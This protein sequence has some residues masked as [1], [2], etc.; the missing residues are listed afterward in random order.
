M[1]AEL[2]IR[3]KGHDRIDI[4]SGA[5]FC[6]TAMGLTT[7]SFFFQVHSK[8]YIERDS[9]VHYY[10]F[11]LHQDVVNAKTLHL[12]AKGLFLVPLTIWNLNSG[13][14][15]HMFA[16]AHNNSMVTLHAM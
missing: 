3:L 10:S 13:T 2:S 5:E 6:R 11:I 12:P 7:F 8:V 14:P 4:I 15:S 9:W 1:A 16:T